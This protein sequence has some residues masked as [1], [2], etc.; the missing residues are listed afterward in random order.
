MTIVIAITMITQNSFSQRSNIK[1]HTFNESLQE[2]EAIS[3]FL[4]LEKFSSN[5]TFELIRSTVDK[6][7]FTHNR[8]QQ[9]YKGIKVEFGTLITHSQ[10]GNVIQLDAEIYN[11]SR[12]NLSPSIDTNTSLTKAIQHLHIQESKWYSNGNFKNNTTLPQSE[13][14]L[15]PDYTNNLS[16]LILAYKI[17]VDASTPN[18]KGDVYIDAN[19][20]IKILF[21]PKMKHFNR[22]FKN[23]KQ[24]NSNKKNRFSTSGAAETRYLG[25]QNIETREES[26]GTYTLN[27]DANQIFTK[28]ALHGDENNREY[29]TVYEEFS[30]NDNNWTSA[31]YDNSNQ[32]N[33]ALDAHYGAMKVK[34][35]WSTIHN[36]NS[37]D[38]NGASIFSFVHVGTNYFN[39]FWDG[40]AM[41]YGDGNSNPLTTFD[42]CAHE[43]GHAVT[44]NTANLVYAN[45]SGAL[46]EGYSDIWG[47][48]IQHY[49]YGTGTDTAPDNDVWAIGEDIGAIRSMNNPNIYGH[50]DT[51]LGSYWRETGD[52]GNCSPNNNNDQCGV[53]SNSGVFNHWF[54][55]L[56]S[57]KTGTND[58]GNSYNVT[59]IGMQKAEEIAYLTLRDYLTPNATLEQAREATLTVAS[60]LYC[61][62]SF[63]VQNLQNAWFAINVG[64]EYQGA[65]DDISLTSITEGTDIS[66]GS[67]FSPEIRLEN[68]GLNPISS[69]DIEY[70][71][72]GGDAIDSTINLAIDPCQSATHTFDLPVLDPGVH[73][74]DITTTVL[75]D[76]RANNN[77]RSTVAFSNEAGENND[78]NTFETTSDNLI[79]YNEGNAINSL[80]NR[81][82][83][84]TPLLGD[85]ANNVYATS[86]TAN[87]PNN[88]KTYLVSKCYDLTSTDDAIL[89]FKMAFDL[90]TNWDIMYVEYT[91]NGGTDWS[92]LGTANDPNWYNSD[93]TPS[94]DCINCPGSQWTGVGENTNSDGVTNATLQEYSYIL[95]DFDLNSS[96][97]AS[98]IIFRF[99]FHA[100]EAVNE[101]G[102]IIDDFS[103]EGTT[104]G[105]KED[106]FQNF[107]YIP[108]P[109]TGILN[110]AFTPSTSNKDILIDLYD[111][112][113]RKVYSESYKTTARFN[114]ILNL[115]NLNTGMYLIK[116]SQGNLQQIA[117]VVLQ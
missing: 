7:G 80:W 63:E 18:L 9:F 43:I 46:N 42:I 78:I 82:I 73:I 22:S 17:A 54:Y 15:V 97:P 75:N 13:L 57:G 40:T 36:R 4:S 81:G 12:I 66:C 87:Y 67:S 41:S 1:K 3:K 59:G 92:I 95:S 88:T 16:S 107:S 61:Y 32:D 115:N 30:D 94:S 111:I 56:V 20:G 98:D 44:S 104:L 62:N 34:E 85:S 103:I 74:I 53:H 70:S 71:I 110:I 93:R 51:Y 14:L 89:R 100:D 27:D 55:I 79:A 6:A 116:V 72:D 113:G 91:V 25:T 45:Q 19:S 29:Y 28:D 69:I 23:N 102:V 99:T 38:D 114:T 68:A 65:D 39:A 112:S 2:R 106:V 105:I 76:G 33:A 10:H 48:A 117:K 26:N 108:N 90:E 86:L 96:S 35:Y 83:V 5:N 64:D 109:T 50:P 52:E 49:V 21:N 31:E 37:Y 84:T 24:P 8:Y 60:N 77:T 58:V 101:E 47:A 11:P